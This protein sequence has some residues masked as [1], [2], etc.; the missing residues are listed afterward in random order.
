M[1]ELY[2]AIIGRIQERLPQ[3]YHIAYAPNPLQRYVGQPS[4]AVYQN[5]GGRP[6]R[7]RGFRFYDDK[8]D[9]VRFDNNQR[10]NEGAI[11][12]TVL[13]A[14]PKSFELLELWAKYGI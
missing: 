2:D 8:I 12:K 5:F 10:F 11:I 14:D 3:P 6:Q 1:I 13:L 9:C 4:Y 7:V